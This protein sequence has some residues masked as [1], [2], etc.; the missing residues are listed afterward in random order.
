MTGKSANNFDPAPRL[1]IAADRLKCTRLKT[2]LVGI[3]DRPTITSAANP[4]IKQTVQLR[5]RKHRLAR[6]QIVVDGAREVLKALA[7]QVVPYEAFVCPPL[8]R[9]ATARAA[10]ESLAAATSVWTTSP[11]VFERLAFGDR[12]DGVVLVAETPQRSLSAIRLPVAALVV[13][14]DG[15]EKPGNVGAVLRT[16]D[17]AGVSAVIVAEASTDLFNPNTIRASLGTVFT[18]PFCAASGAETLA[19]LRSQRL[20][21]YAARVDGAQWY[22]DVRLDR[23]TAMVLGSEAHGLGPE[24][25]GDDIRAIRLPMLGAADSLNVSATAAVLCYEAL[26]QRRASPA[27]T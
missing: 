25:Q 11:E 22:T 17:A 3:M 15:V 9:T 4:R 24:W 20:S 12:S 7:A 5:E 8:C 27:V 6:G 21:I 23:A 2:G 1:A 10:L 19:W 14:L 26:R 16:A 13:V 18:V